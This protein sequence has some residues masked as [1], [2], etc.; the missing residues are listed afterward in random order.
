MCGNSDAHC[1]RSGNAEAHA[2]HILPVVDGGPDIVQNGIALS[3]TIHWLFDYYLISL[4]EDH[5]LV[6]AEN[7]V[8]SEL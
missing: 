3:G 8:P 5:R 6:V 2:A 7:G 1:G 4:T